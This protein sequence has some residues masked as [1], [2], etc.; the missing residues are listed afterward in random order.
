[1]T[2]DY[3]HKISIGVEGI[4]DGEIPIYKQEVVNNRPID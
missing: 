4:W 1:M 3:L 2:R